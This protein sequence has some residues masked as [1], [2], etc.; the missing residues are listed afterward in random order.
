MKRIISKKYF[1]LMLVVAGMLS[2][3]GDPVVDIN[4]TVY[5]SKI[6]VNG[7]L[8]PNEPVKDIFITRNFEINTPI[9]TTTLFLT[10]QTNAAVVKINDILLQFDQATK[11]YFNNNINVEYGTTYRLDIE[12]V[13]DGIQ[14]NTYCYTT[15][16]NE[17]FRVL[18]N[19]LD[20]LKYRQ[21]DIM[22]NFFPSPGTTFYVF[23]IIADSASYDNF[24][25]N[26]PLL[27]NYPEDEFNLNYNSFR[28]QWNMLLN[29]NSYSQDPI[30]FQI[31]DFD[32]WFYSSYKVIVYAGDENFKDYFLT[33]KRV[34]QFDGNFIEPEFHFAGDGIGV[35]GSAI[36]DTVT[37]TLI[38]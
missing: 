30:E 25:T 9:D 8:Y 16:P 2:S 32:T 12:A 7:F 10:P 29:I 27:P 11:T 23:S 21:S 19:D 1:V 15:T 34:Q 36:R 3:C 17:G 26:N 38:P 18:D 20:T 14:L 22:I 13:V 33:A 24:I 28:F 35:F 37:F 4:E 5:T 31:R 6:A